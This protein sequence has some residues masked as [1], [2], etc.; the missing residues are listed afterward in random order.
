MAK[1]SKYIDVEA[2]E[3]GDELPEEDEE[4]EEEAIDDDDL[5]SEGEE[6]PFVYTSLQATRKRCRV[7][8]VELQLKVDLIGQRVDKILEKINDV[9]SFL[10]RV[11]AAQGCNKGSAK[12]L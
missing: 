6:E 8:D 12:V 7:D 5:S 1:P 10:R 2:E 3:S 9:D 4:V 11:V